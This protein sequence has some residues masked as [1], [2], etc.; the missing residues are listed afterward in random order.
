MLTETTS[1][2]PPNGSTVYFSWTEEHKH[3]LAKYVHRNFAYKKTTQSYKEKFEIILFQLK[4]KPEFSTLNIAWNALQTA[5][6]RD[7][8][9][10][11]A[12]FG[13]SKEQVNLSG[14]N[15]M[16]AEYEKLHLDMAEEDYKESNERK[17][18]SAKVVA[19][20]R[21]NNVV[22]KEGLKKQGERNYKK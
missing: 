11:L 6:K 15:E 2:Q 8:A 20:K 13:I 17:S 12:K 10:V 7:Q 14:L 5:F 19:Q 9:V 16:P 1:L 21:L 22:A 4:Q 3:I 18:K